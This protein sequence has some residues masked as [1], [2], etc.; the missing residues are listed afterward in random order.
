VPAIA[1]LFG[2]CA[3]CAGTPSESQSGNCHAANGNTAA[4]A[5]TI[6]QAPTVCRA[7]NAAGEGRVGANRRYEEQYR[8][9]LS[10]ATPTHARDAAFEQAEERASFRVTRAMDA[11]FLYMRPE[12]TQP[13][14]PLAPLPV[15]SRS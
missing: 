11:P 10:I 12:R 13:S 6:C 1:D 14:M 2:T 8:F 4:L 7:L 15:R 9:K 5:S 3:R